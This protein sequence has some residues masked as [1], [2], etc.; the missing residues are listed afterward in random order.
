MEEFEFNITIVATGSNVDEAFENAL[1]NL[2]EDPFGA[3]RGEV[4]YV[5]KTT[6]GEAEAEEEK[7]EE[8]EFMN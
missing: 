2:V 5:N 8:T 4:V 6:S 7:K 3:I 1:S